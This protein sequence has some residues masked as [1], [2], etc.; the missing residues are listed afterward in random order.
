MDAVYIF[1]HI[2]VNILR[3]GSC[4]PMLIHFFDS[5]F[6][7]RGAD[8]K[9]RWRPSLVGCHSHTI[10]LIQD[11]QIP[12][13]PHIQATWYGTPLCELTVKHILNLTSTTCKEGLT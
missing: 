3:I 10:S 1:R 2:E 12:G 9:L 8:T 11:Q 6:S 5:D 7:A 4:M 13:V